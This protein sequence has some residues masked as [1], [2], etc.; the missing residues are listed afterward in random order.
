VLC[1]ISSR[2]F[3]KYG[4][5]PSSPI[6]ANDITRI[7]IKEKN[8]QR[9]RMVLIRRGITPPWAMR[10]GRFLWSLGV[11]LPIACAKEGFSLSSRT[12][13][14]ETKEWWERAKDML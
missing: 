6:N 4:S 11:V 9:V 12:P 7:N 10:G 13:V 5:S 8:T 1:A 2:V 14:M 3:L